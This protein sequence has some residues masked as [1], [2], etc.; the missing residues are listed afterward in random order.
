MGAR[1]IEEIRSLIYKWFFWAPFLP[2]RL[3]PV[4]MYIFRLL[5]LIHRLI[6]TLMTPNHLMESLYTHN[7]S[8]RT[9]HQDRYQVEPPNLFCP[10]YYYCTSVVRESCYSVCIYRMT[11][12]WCIRNRRYNNKKGEQQLVTFTDSNKQSMTFPYRLADVEGR[13]DGQYVSEFNDGISIYYDDMSQSY[14]WMPA[15]SFFQNYN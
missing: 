13:Q 10:V 12:C 2:F 6:P 3:F 7:S 11:F 1:A 4:G 8:K 15:H 14:Y 9:S 5:W